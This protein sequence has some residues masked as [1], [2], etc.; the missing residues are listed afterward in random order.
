[1]MRVGCA[2]LAL[3]FASPSLGHEGAT[4][5]V[6]ER[7]D[8]MKALGAL[9]KAMAEKIK[10]NRNLPSLADDAKEIAAVSRRI[11]SWFPPGSTQAPTEASPAIWADFSAFEAQAAAMQREAL[12]LAAIAPSGDPA[13]IAA[14]FR[15]MAAACKSCHDGFRTKK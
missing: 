7:M 11:P 15:T 3:A 4:G 13:P 5:I 8:A 12:S 14:Q 2:L 10:G 6:K 9:T 1:M